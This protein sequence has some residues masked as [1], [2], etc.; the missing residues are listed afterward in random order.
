MENN[1]RE[2]TGQIERRLEKLR[3]YAEAKHYKGWDPFDGLNSKVFQSVPLLKKHKWTRLAWLQF[4]KRSPLNFRPLFLVPETENPKGLALF[5]L[6]Y[7]RLYERDPRP[8]YRERIDYLAGRLLQ[9]TSS[10][11]EGT[12][13]GYPFD[14]QARAFFQPAGTPNAVVTAYAAEALWEAA[15][16]TGNESYART[17]DR[18]GIF[19]LQNLH[20]TFDE[21]G[22]YI[23]S[24][25][26]LDRTSIFNAG[27]LAAK[28]LLR[29]G[30]RTGNQEWVRAALPPFRYT[31]RRQR[32]DGS[33]PYGTLPH[34]RWTDNFH[35]GYVLEAYYIL[36]ELTG[37]DEFDEI[38]RKGTDYYLRTFWTPEGWPRY[39]HNRLWPVDMHNPAQLAVTA[40]AGDLWEKA[41][42]LIR[43]VFDRTLPPMQNPKG[44]FY[45]RKYKW[46]RNK[47]P[48]M[49][50][51][52]AWMFYGLAT[53]LAELKKREQP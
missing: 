48:Y 40:R 25:S 37:T 23:F 18:T 14:W 53:L 52:Q 1:L 34:H 11:K 20:K 49:R 38:I 5:L 50:W 35:T 24:Y 16:L 43:R 41:L 26:P 2:F 15:R 28:T 45:Y 21:H 17:A 29:A 36:R 30:I 4:F 22:D 9:T 27:L 51:I 32:P 44:Y 19:I 8:E 10:V 39:Y 47:I 6:G 13:W 3:R 33:W 31:A 42:P 7:A 46:F 12:G